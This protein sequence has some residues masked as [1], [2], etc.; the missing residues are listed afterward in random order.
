MERIMKLALIG[1]IT[2]GLLAALGVAGLIAFGSAKSPGVLAAVTNPFAAIDYSSLPPLQKYQARDGTALYFRHYAA[3]PNQVAVLIHGAAGSSGD[4]H[5]LALAL[6]RAG[7][8]VYVPD[9]RGHGANLPH[10]DIA[11]VGQ[12]DD[13]MSDFMAVEKPAL[14]HAA[15]C[16]VGFSSGGGFALRIAAEDPLGRLFDR[17]ILLSPYLKYNAPSTR[18]LAADSKSP[19]AAAAPVSIENWAAAAR[20]RII[21]L[22]IANRFGVRAFDGLPVV[23][24]AVPANIDTVTKE[25]SWRLQRNFQPHDSYVADI[26]AVSRPMR[27]YVGAV[28]QLFIPE[29]L[30]GEFQAQRRDIPVSIIPAMGHTD[31]ITNPKAIELIAAEFER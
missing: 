29:K 3:G 31:M 28:D 8:T 22:S 6:Q 11:Y 4:M 5:L 14:P 12:L 16:L 25:Y 20:G 30:Q 10:G 7:V 24:F 15:W 23:A 9:I 21:G 19:P 26:R 17:Y 27:V 1:I 13:D 18:T 2:L